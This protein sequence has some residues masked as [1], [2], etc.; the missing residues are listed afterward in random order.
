M[1][2]V[3]EASTLSIECY[4]EFSCPMIGI[5][6]KKDKAASHEKPEETLFAFVVMR[7]MPNTNF[8]Q[9]LMLCGD[10]GRPAR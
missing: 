7:L 6:L 2:G 4:S 10:L 1:T 3:N 5:V 9:S 8:L